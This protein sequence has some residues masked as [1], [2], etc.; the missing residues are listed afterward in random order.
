[1]GSQRNWRNQRKDK[2][3]GLLHFFFFQCVGWEF[4]CGILKSLLLFALGYWLFMS[5]VG[6]TS[7]PIFKITHD[8]AREGAWGPTLICW[9]GCC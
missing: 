1:M 5:V 9:L 3:I 7:G 4:S 2:T 6:F 8:L